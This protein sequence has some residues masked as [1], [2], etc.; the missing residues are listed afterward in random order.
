MPLPWISVLRD[1]AASVSGRLSRRGARTCLLLLFAGLSLHAQRQARPVDPA[2]L[3]AR[4]PFTSAAD[5]AEG[6]RMFMGRCALC[7]GQMGEGGRG[8]ALKPGQSDRERFVIVRMGIPNSEMPPSFSQ[9]DQEIWRLVAFVQQ[10]GSGGGETEVFRGDATVGKGVF[11]NQSCG[12]CHM[13]DGE[14]SDFGPDLSQAGVRTPRYLKESILNPDADV[15]VTY[16]SVSV[17]TS[18]GAT[19]RGIF[20]GEDEYSIQLRDMKGSPRSFLKTQL[21][22]VQHEASSLMPAFTM[23]STDLDNLVAYLSSLKGKR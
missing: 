3:P 14:G 8:P 19:V 6:K 12:V 23:P 18:A 10:L 4:N 17:V 5:I 9:T 20:I 2:R 15:P 16:H 7:H 11:A 1:P 13:I 22:E 21:R